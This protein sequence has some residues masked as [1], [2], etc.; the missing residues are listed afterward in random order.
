MA[1]V[2]TYALLAVFAGL[3]AFAWWVDGRTEGRF[4][5]FRKWS[6]VLQVAAV[7]AAVMLLRPGHG[8]HDDPSSFAATVGHGTPVLIDVFSNS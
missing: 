1:P 6:L 3:F 7:G 8:S 5:P 2:F 4:A